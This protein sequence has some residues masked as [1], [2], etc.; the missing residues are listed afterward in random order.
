MNTQFYSY[1]RPRSTHSDVLV[2]KDIKFTTCP[3]TSS[4]LVKL[5][6]GDWGLVSAVNVST[7][8]PEVQKGQTNKVTPVHSEHQWSS[9]QRKSKSKAWVRTRWSITVIYESLY[10]FSWCAN[11]FL[12]FTG[13]TF[14]QLQGVNESN[15]LVWYISGKA[16]LRQFDLKP[17][18]SPLQLA[19]HFTH[20]NCR[21]CSA[22]IKTRMPYCIMYAQHMCAHL[23]FTCGAIMGNYLPTLISL[24]KPC[25]S[26]TPLDSFK[27]PMGEKVKT[28]SQ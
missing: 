17:R 25:L 8:S 4:G 5:V 13:V 23:S 7:G 15:H 18:A 27:R 16:T 21:M 2:A 11:S 10:A 3:C 22:T 1:T 24:Y 26:I 9:S 6:G 12:S 14:T 20:C 28:R 19:D